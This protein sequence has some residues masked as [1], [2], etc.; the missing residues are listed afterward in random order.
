MTTTAI[1]APTATQTPTE[2]PA[3][4]VIPARR[5][6]APLPA[7]RNARPRRSRQPHCRRPMPHQRTRPCRRV[8]PSRTLA[9]RP[10]HQQERWRAG[11]AGRAADLRDRRRQQRRRPGERCGRHRHAA[12]RAERVQRDDDPRCDHGRGADAYGGDGRMEPGDDSRHGG[13][14]VDS[15]ASPATTRILPPCDVQRRAGH[16]QQHRAG[17]GQHRDG[18][19]GAAGVATAAPGG[20]PLDRRGPRTRHADRSIA[21]AD[22][23]ATAVPPTQPPPSP[24]TSVPP[25]AL[26]RGRSGRRRGRR[27]GAAGRGSDPGLAWLLLAMACW[28]L[29]GGSLLQ[30]RRLEQDAVARQTR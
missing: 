8:R 22:A 19:H 16:R 23:P 1:A 18:A 27:C 14:Q 5:R 24:P 12:G 29:A 15:A 21:R 2:G 28:L 4:T 6:T 30:L 11:A 13:G 3:P 25:T 9:I 10:G 26:S 17:T 20:Q 7:Y